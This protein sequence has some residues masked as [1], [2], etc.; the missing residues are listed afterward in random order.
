MADSID[1]HPLLLKLWDTTKNGAAASVQARSFRSAWWRCDHGHAFQRAP[2][3]MLGDPTCPMCALGPRAN[4][5]ADSSST[6]ALLW[7]PEKNASLTP[8]TVDIAHSGPIWWRCDSGHEFQRPP[9]LMAR[10]ASCPMCTASEKSLA[11]TNPSVAAEWHPKRNGEVTPAQV[12]PDHVMNVWWRCPNGHEYQAT[13]RSRVRADRRCPT[14]YGGWSLDNLRSFVKSLL[15][16]V[17]AL[18]PSELFALAMQAGAFADKDSR[19]FV[20]AISTGK[21]PMDELEKFAEGKPSLVDQFAAQKDLTLEIVDGRGQEFKPDL[22][23]DPFALPGAPL[24]V[25]RKSVV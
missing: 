5:V 2:R 1:A 17:G 13:V 11:M 6:L 15:G 8:A 20:M 25:D 4:F 12:D 23:A 9:L 24:P 10:D 21:F 14:C 3:A 19:P 16:H 18:N 22:A 7:H